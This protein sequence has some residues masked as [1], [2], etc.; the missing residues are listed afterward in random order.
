MD[1]VNRQPF[2]HMLLHGL[3]LAVRFTL[4]WDASFRSVLCCDSYIRRIRCTVPAHTS[5]C[6]ISDPRR[7]VSAT[8][9]LLSS[10][11][12]RSVPPATTLRCC[13]IV[14]FP[15]STFITIGNA[16]FACDCLH[17]TVRRAC[18][19]FARR[20]SP[21]NDRSRCASLFCPCASSPCNLCSC[22]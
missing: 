17:S 7:L 18:P 11:S 2:L 12:L 13:S 9:L 20:H 6:A 1:S 15:L 21:L 3:W 8:S 10:P 14:P 22:L 19:Q 5:T 16:L 4:C